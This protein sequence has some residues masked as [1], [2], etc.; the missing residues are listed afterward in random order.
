MRGAILTHGDGVVSRHEDGARLGQ[1]GD[2]NG[3]A[4]VVGEDGE[5][6]AV[7][8]D[9]CLVQG[10]GVAHR[11]HAELAD[12]EAHVALRVAA[13]QKV[14][15]ALHQRHVGWRQVGRATHEL[16]QHIGDGVQAVL[17]VEA[18]CLALVLSGKLG[19]SLPPVLR[20]LA[21]QDSALELRGE[22]RLLLLVLLPH[23][24][25]GL[26]LLSAG[27]GVLAEGVVDGV[28]HLE[29]SVVPAQLLACGLGLIGT[30]RGAMGIV[31]VRL[32]G[33]PEAD[34]RLHLDERGLVRAGLGLLDGLPDGTH[35]RVALLHLQHLPAVSLEA[36]PHILS[37]GEVRMPVNGDAVV[38]VEGDQLAQA[39]VAGI[40]AGLM[41]DALLHAAVTGNC[42]GV[43]INQR[44][45]RFVVHCR[46]VRLGS[47]QAHCVR[48]AHAQRSRGHL[49]AVRLEVLR[50]A[51]GLGAPLAELLQVVQAHAVEAR[52]VQQR[53]LEHAPV[54]GGQHEAVP[55]RP[56]GV[57][58]VVL[59]LLCEEQISDGRLAHGGS[60]VAA[61]GLVH[62]VHRQEANGVD[63]LGVHVH[64]RGRPLAHHLGRRS[65]LRPHRPRCA[66]HRHRRAEHCAGAA[67]G[68]G[69][70]GGAAGG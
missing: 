32:V 67:G 70:G 33:G 7:G 29:L 5:G 50:V 21:V 37:E 12:A 17:R 40:G 43:V 63:A 65:A 47:S 25:P 1:R 13:R 51:W 60:R 18:G 48:D 8:D 23:L 2:A 54:P 16:G 35:V 53:V 49:D 14:P 55:V 22:L 9:A 36:L 66:G 59:H 38:V 62:R 45:V 34:G 31:A 28:R 57:L 3:A 10:H 42:V 4:H 26:L 41:G 39:Q 20:Q 68:G 46:K 19:Q 30:Q 61:V 27:L 11:A 6:G 69:S 44:H 64:V 56:L 24:L 58:R 52:Q 15:G